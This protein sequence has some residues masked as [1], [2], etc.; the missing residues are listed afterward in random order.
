LKET[1]VAQAIE[2][3]LK[4]FVVVNWLKG[5]NIRREKLVAAVLDKNFGESLSRRTSGDLGLM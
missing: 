3:Q 4:G 5:E 2:N 1:T